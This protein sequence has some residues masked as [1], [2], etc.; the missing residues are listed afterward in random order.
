LQLSCGFN[1]R[2]TCLFRGWELQP[3]RRIWAKVKQRSGP[4]K[5]EIFP[6][7]WQILASW[8]LFSPLEL[9]LADAFEC[10]QTCLFRGWKLQFPVQLKRSE[11]PIIYRNAKKYYKIFMSRRAFTNF[12]AYF[13]PEVLQRQRWGNSILGSLLLQF[14]GRDFVKI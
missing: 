13:K 10:H 3:P 4:S 9:T 2:S 6:C 14:S 11:T 1:C 7:I 8:R 12:C 5:T